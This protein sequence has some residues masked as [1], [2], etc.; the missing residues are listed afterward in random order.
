MIVDRKSTTCNK[1]TRR[2]TA[3]HKYEA[4]AIQSMLEEIEAKLAM[5]RVLT[6]LPLDLK[7]DREK[8][9]LLE[10]DAKQ[11][12]SATRVPFKTNKVLK[13]LDNMSEEGVKTVGDVIKFTARELARHRNLGRDSIRYMET[14]LA[15]YGLYLKDLRPGE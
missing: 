11:F 2:R 10:M 9:H 13:W 8:Q 12:F 5:I 6:V 15:K 3:V 14:C 4:K 7:R 1:T